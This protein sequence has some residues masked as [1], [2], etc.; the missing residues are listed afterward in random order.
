MDLQFKNQVK[1]LTD[2][3]TESFSIRVVIASYLWILLNHFY[4]LAK[5]HYLEKN[6]Y[7]ALCTQLA[8]L[9]QEAIHFRLELQNKGNAQNV[10]FLLGNS[11]FNLLLWNSGCRAGIFLLKVNNRNT[12]KRC[13]I[14]SK[15]TIKIPERRQWRLLVSLLL[16]LN[17][18]HTLF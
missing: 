1:W 17:I 6:D 16:T 3:F 13:E 4:W 12:R 11:Q 8:T 2:W 7:Q 15:L 9:I 14:C 5:K 10:A 18:F